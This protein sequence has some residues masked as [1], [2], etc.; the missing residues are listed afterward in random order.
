MLPGNLTSF[1]S[2]I[3]LEN[4]TFS[5]ILKLLIHTPFPN[6]CSDDLASTSL[7][8]L[9]KQQGEN[10]HKL[11]HLLTQQH[12]CPYSLP[13]P[14]LLWTTCLGSYAK[15]SPFI[16]KLNFISFHLLKDIT[17]VILLSLSYLTI[18]S[19]TPESFLLLI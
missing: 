9:K 12:L 7:R 17:P 3:L 4:Y 13:L 1:H 19:L 6:S 11:P 2:T 15:A 10:C 5:S 18:F 14:I 8:K 16:Q